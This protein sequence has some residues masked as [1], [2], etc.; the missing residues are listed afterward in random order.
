M[1]LANTHTKDFFHYK[2]MRAAARNFQQSC[3]VMTAALAPAVMAGTMT[4]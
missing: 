2:V 1:S 3:Y 4:A